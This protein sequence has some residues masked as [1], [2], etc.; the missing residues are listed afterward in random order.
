[1]E[2]W[3]SQGFYRISIHMTISLVISTYSEIHS[4]EACEY[5]GEAPTSQQNSVSRAQHSKSTRSVTDWQAQVDK[6]SADSS[7]LTFQDM[8]GPETCLKFSNK[9]N[10]MSLKIWGQGQERWLNC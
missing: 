3:G 4:S 10:V 2:S 1:M 5:L 7:H 9:S 6:P 8:T